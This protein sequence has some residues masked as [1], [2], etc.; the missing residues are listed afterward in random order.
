MV[1]TNAKRLFRFVNAVRSQS[2]RA[3]Y[4]VE[5]CDTLTKITCDGSSSSTK[6]QTKYDNNN[7]NDNDNQD[8][9]SNTKSNTSFPV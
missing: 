3:S 1:E 7:N 2:V 4:I 5:S 9:K 6:Q 8:V